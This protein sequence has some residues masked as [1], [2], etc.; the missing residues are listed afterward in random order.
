MTTRPAHDADVIRRI[1]LQTTRELENVPGVLA[2]A[3]WL[4]DLRQ[5]RE[6]YITAAHDA[7]I[8]AVRSA[9]R[10]VLQQNGLLFSP[11][12]V[13]IAA[14]DHAPDP[15]RARTGRFL[16]LESLEADRGDNSVSCRVRL[17][18][19]GKSVS[20]EARDVDSE[21]GRAR[22]AARATLL[23]AEQAAPNVRLGIE[24]LQ[25][26]ELFGRRYVVLAVEAIAARRFASLA[27]I[28][29]IDR[30]IEDAACLAAL[31]AIDRWLAR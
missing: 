23:A 9:V 6:A 31:G 2:A 28:N 8:D 15:S 17:L 24:G 5:I 25:I 11:D 3:V 26:L 29:E 20:G 12:V 4:R 1:E 18:H 27:G 14:L 19:D 21:T 30:S 7:S 10:Q 13:H 22:A 16:L